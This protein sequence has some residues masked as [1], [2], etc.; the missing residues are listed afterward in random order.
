[1]GGPSLNQYLVEFPTE[2]AYECLFGVTAFSEADALDLIAEQVFH[3]QTIPG[4]PT[5]KPV[6][7]FW[8][9]RSLAIRIPRGTAT[10]RGIWH[11]EA[12][13]TKE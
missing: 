3:H 12:Y 10:K 2:L 6:P 8:K 4:K 7:P 1:M 11:P 13:R 9:R 5:I